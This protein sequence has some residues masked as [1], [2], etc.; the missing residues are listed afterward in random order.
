MRVV[1]LL[2]AVAMTAHAQPADG[3]FVVGRFDAAVVDS[4]ALDYLVALPDGYADDDTT[5]W[6]LVLFLHG[7]G[8][9]GADLARLRVHGPTRRVAEGARV[10][11]VLVA[12]Q[13]PEGSWWDAQQ[14]GALLDRIE[15]TYRIDAD[16]ISVTGLSMGGYGTW[17]LA[18]AFPTR[19][20]AIAPVC[21][22][23]TP[24]RIAA[25][26]EAGL[27]MWVF[28]GALDDVVP[29]QRSI[30]MVQRVQRH[31]GDV[32]LTLYPDAGHDSWT[33]TYANPELYDW[34]MAQRRP[35]R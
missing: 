19:F 6:P 8:E 15:Q 4:V 27:P 13:A 30:E 29:V 20:A 25:A 5:R 10:P 28:H 2:A 31:G 16:R 22:G 35:A 14:L 7:S 1:L 32:R 12:P 33:E 11:F 24:S 21:G 18:E 34:L 26:A 23:G 3:P 9:R 17:A